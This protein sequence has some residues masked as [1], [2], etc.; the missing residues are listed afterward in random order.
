MA[1]GGLH[2]LVLVDDGLFV[3]RLFRPSWSGDRFIALIQTLDRKN[4]TFEYKDQATATTWTT[5]STVTGNGA[6]RL[7]NDPSATGAQ[8]FY[9]VRQ[10]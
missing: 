8:R 4:Y 5:L 9:R 7:L 6:L 2:T 3:P 10:W 1:A